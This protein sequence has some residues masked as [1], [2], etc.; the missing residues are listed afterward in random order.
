MQLWDLKGI[1]EQKGTE[2]LDYK[3]GIKKLRPLS[4]W[5]SFI[6]VDGVD[7]NGEMMPWSLL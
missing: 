5:F 4:S 2:V 3:F 7:H 6:N 1:K